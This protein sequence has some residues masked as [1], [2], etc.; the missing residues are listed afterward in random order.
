MKK[1]LLF[2]MCSTLLFPM[3]SLAD[4]VYKWVDAEGKTHYGDS[5]EAKDA[6]VTNAESIDVKD[7]NAYNPDEAISDEMRDTLNKSEQT[8]QEEAEKQRQKNAENAARD[9]A[10]AREINSDNDEDWEDYGVYYQGQPLTDAQRRALAAHKANRQPRNPG[11]NLGTA[12]P[13]PHSKPGG[14]MS[15]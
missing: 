7:A 13:T 6:G 4:K 3:L 1:P 9:A 11:N 12:T 15:R 8:R 5:K 10:I 2:F 14:K